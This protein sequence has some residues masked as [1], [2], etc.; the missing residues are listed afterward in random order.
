MLM[1]S[2]AVASVIATLLTS[3]TTFATAP[4]KPVSAKTISKMAK[5]NRAR[6]LMDARATQY[7]VAEGGGLNAM[8]LFVPV[9][10]GVG[11]AAAS[12]AFNSSN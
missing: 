6:S 10:V 12:G 11:V 1:K 3:T 2:L 8:G 4:I 5:P 7:Q 9:A